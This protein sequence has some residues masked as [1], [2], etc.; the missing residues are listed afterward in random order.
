MNSDPNEF[1]TLRKLMAL[2]RHEQPPP[3]YL[4]QLPNTI[5]HRIELGECRLTLWERI[6][7][8]VALRPTLVYAMGL[9]MCGA[10]GLSAIFLAKDEMARTADASSG[11]A[12][13]GV[14]SATAY[15]APVNPVVPPIHVAN[16]LGNTNPT[17]E[18]QPQ[19]SLFEASPRQVMPVA[20]QTG[21]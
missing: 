21:Y 13:R 16:W 15:A 3:G 10:L 6:S 8:N 14:M 18:T 11:L 17:V 1:E 12:L 9:T 19:L 2:K 7:T 4:N 5:I 20:Y